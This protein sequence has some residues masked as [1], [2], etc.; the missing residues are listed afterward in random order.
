MSIDQRVEKWLQEQVFIDWLLF[1]FAD[2]RFQVADQIVVQITSTFSSEWTRMRKS[3][4][5]FGFVS[6]TWAR[7][8]K[9][10]CYTS[11]VIWTEK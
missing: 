11:L 8:P 5:I 9:G 4:S 2:K 6:A 1:D 7:E 3:S 10:E